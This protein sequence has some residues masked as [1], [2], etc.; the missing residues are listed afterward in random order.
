MLKTFTVVSTSS[1]ALCA[2][3]TLIPK[4]SAIIPNL[5]FLYSGNRYFANL[6]VSIYVLFNFN[7]NAVALY[8]RKPISKSALCATKTLSPTNSSTLGNT[9][10]IVSASFTISSVILVTSTTF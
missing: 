10:S 9:L 8:F 6:K 3:S 7:P 1:N 4:F 2:T 5:Y